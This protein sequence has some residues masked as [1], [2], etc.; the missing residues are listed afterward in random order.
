[1]E[2]KKT[3][4]I[5][6]D[7]STMRLFL[8]KVLGQDDYFTL[9]AASGQEALEQIR[10]RPDI[11]LILMD[12]RLPDIPCGDPKFFTEIRDLKPDVPIVVL[13]GYVSREVVIK[14][15]PFKIT[16]FIA[17]PIEKDQLLK[18]IQKII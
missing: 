16:E 1:M 10:S 4:L 14:L 12:L 7:V 18:K 3:I 17:K 6:E 5:V 8:S 11:E 15:S 13:S 9:T 2:R